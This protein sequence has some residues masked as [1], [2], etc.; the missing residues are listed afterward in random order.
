MKM[1]EI[2]KPL[3]MIKKFN[4]EINEE[5]FQT[6]LVCTT[7]SSFNNSFLCIWTKEWEN[8]F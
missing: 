7:Q 4:V 8:A 6:Q 2:S 1:D 3:N 5:K